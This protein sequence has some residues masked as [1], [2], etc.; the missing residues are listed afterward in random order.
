MPDLR[1]ARFL[2]LFEQCTPRNDDVAPVLLEFGDAE[3]VDIADV[4]G[5]FGAQDV[6]L[7]KRAERSL[8]CDADLEAALDLLLDPSFH[9]QAGAERVLELS[10]G[11]GAAR[12]LPR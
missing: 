2:L 10:H 12:Q 6:D 11:S 9:G 1:R 7:R 4:N 8:P 3:R 5:G